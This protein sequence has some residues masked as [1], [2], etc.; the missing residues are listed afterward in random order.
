MLVDHPAVV[1]EPELSGRDR[2]RDRARGLDEDLDI[3]HRTD[4]DAH[5]VGPA[6]YGV[7]Q[8]EF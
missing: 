2:E 8:L 4:R 1:N 5:R 6:S 7:E 3:L